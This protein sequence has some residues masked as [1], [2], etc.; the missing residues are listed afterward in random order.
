MAG[1]AEMAGFVVRG[2]RGIRGIHGRLAGVVV[3]IVWGMI[4]SVPAVACSSATEPKPPG[5]QQPEAL[6]TIAELKS[7]CAG[8]VSLPVR[9]DAVIRGAI[10]ANDL[11]GEFYKTLVIEDASGGISIAADLEP[12]A[13]EYPWGAILTVRCNG[14]WLCEYGGKIMLGSEPG[15]YGAGR[16]PRDELPRYLSVSMPDEEE[17]P[18]AAVV[19]ID[20]L[21]MQHVDTRVRID[22]VRFE[23][24]GIPWCDVDPVSG[25]TLT[26]E[27]TVVDGDGN[28]LAVRTAATCIYAKEPVPFGTGSLYGVIDYFAGKFS[29]HVTNREV[30]FDPLSGNP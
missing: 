10:V 7:L 30:V 17:I 4:L 14:L 23:Q 25:R 21:A 18:R 16:I 3:R 13:D 8:K 27:R 2:I 26:T 9:H 19:S 20:Q 22:R 12:L 24:P 29:L 5:D 15:Q 28:S 11:Y 6:I 1:V